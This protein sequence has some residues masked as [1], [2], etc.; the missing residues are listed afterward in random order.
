MMKTDS[1]KAESSPPKPSQKSIDYPS[2]PGLYL[3]EVKSNWLWIQFDH[4]KETNPFSRKLTLALTKLNSEIELDS[5]IRGVVYYGGP[6]RSFSSGGDFNDVSQL[7]TAEETSLYISE[8]I[9]LYQSVLS[10]YKPV[11]SLLDHYVIGQ[12]LQVALMSDWKIAT[13]NVKISMP[14]LKNGVACP[15]GATILRELFGQAGMLADVIGCEMMNAEAAF[16]KGYFNTLATN[17]NLLSTATAII[18]K[19][20]QYPMTPFLE[21]KKIYTKNMIQA[22]ESVREPA[23]H[24]HVQTMFSGS[25][26]KHFERILNRN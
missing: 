10:L 14:E 5:T 7:K 8:I 4:I 24:A 9:D 23:A 20:S 18:E 25:A 11:I 19:L 22:L 17:E 13:Q 21:T 15:L 3:T 16:N 26:T 1:K 6:N 2:N 12:G